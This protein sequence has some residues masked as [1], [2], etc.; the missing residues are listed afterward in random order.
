[1]A[2]LTK[3]EAK[4]KFASKGVANAGLTLGVIGTAL[5]VLNGGGSGFGFGGGSSNA[6]ANAVD[7]DLFWLQNVGIQKSIGD[8]N[9]A[10]QKGD[11]E[12]YITLNKAICDNAVATAQMQSA[13]PYMFQLAKEQAERYADNKICQVEKDLAVSNLVIQRQL[14]Q[15]VNGVIGLP[16]SSII[17]GIPTMPQYTIDVVKASTTSSTSTTTTTTP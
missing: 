10:I 14:D 5:G 15:K 12:T 13:L 4:G 9:V 7:K 17:S 16:W 2:E 11:Y 1:M 8:T 6:L 3:E